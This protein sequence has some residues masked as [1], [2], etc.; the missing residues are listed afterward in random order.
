[1]IQIATDGPI[2]LS[3]QMVSGHKQPQHNYSKVTSSFFLSKVPD[4]STRKD[5]KNHATNQ[6][7]GINIINIVSGVTLQINAIYAKMHTH[8]SLGYPTK[9]SQ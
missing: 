5:T 9:M 1:M 3:A 7:F 2:S 6:E 8:I 4:C